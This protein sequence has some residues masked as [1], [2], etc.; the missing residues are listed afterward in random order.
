MQFQQSNGRARAVGVFAS[1]AMATTL[2][3]CGGSSSSAASPRPA[4]ASSSAPA[5]QTATPTSAA[6][7]GPT[8]TPTLPTTSAPTASSSST[9]LPP[10]WTGAQKSQFIAA[11]DA[12]AANLGNATI[13]CFMAVVPFREA[14][15]LALDYVAVAWKGPLMPQDQ[16]KQALVAKYG[17]TMG[18]QVFDAWSPGGALNW[19]CGPTN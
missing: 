1:A 18:T 10:T 17:Q 16:L 11:F 9:A 8:S 13:A 14:A 3:A 19:G 5:A 12:D 2:A 7:S 15:P 6:S 4:A